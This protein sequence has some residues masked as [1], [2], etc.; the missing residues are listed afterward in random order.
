MLVIIVFSVVPIIY[1]CFAAVLEHEN[2]Y[3]IRYSPY[4][5]DKTLFIKSFLN[6]SQPCLIA[7]PDGFGK[8]TNL[9]MLKNFLSADINNTHGENIFRDTEISKDMNF[10]KDELGNYAVI[11]CSF[12][13]HMPV[14]DYNS[15]MNLFRSILYRTFAMHPYLP[16]S[17]KISTSD[18]KKL[19]WFVGVKK[20]LRLKPSRVFAGLHFLAKLLKS[21]H[22]KEVIL[23]IDDF[24]SI[25]MDSIFTNNLDYEM[26]FGFHNAFFSSVLHDNKNI[27]KTILVGTSCKCFQPLKQLQHLKCFE[28]LKDENFAPFFGITEKEIDQLLAKRDFK[29]VYNRKEDIRQW[30]G[31]YKSPDLKTQVFNTRSTLSFL[32]TGQLKN[33]W[34]NTRVLKTLKLLLIEPA[35]EIL[36]ND[37]IRYKPIEI[38]FVDKI[39][40]THIEG[41][42]GFTDCELW[43]EEFS[44]VFMNLLMDKG[45]FTFAKKWKGNEDKF[46]VTIPNEEI[47]S[48]VEKVITSFLEDPKE[49]LDRLKA[50]VHEMCFDET[51]EEVGSVL[52][53]PILQ[54][55]QQVGKTIGEAKELV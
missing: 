18:K 2:F 55:V 54:E 52:S 33:Y 46:N 8:S 25:I 6:T 27:N 4:F 20:H 28:F 50:T 10:T 3:D 49:L 39:D 24:D 35:V 1:N 16:T 42:R 22:G 29:T 40:Q 11:Y 30:Y 45:Y 19:S 48:V 41:L 43:D 53:E 26:V 9:N 47:R 44:D 14:L 36:L 7:A 15:L 37:S 5:I 13:Q 38:H 51:K 34:A 23:M 31:G 21:Y 32:R 12:K 17:K